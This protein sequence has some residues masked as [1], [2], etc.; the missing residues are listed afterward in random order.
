MINRIRSRTGG[1]KNGVAN[2]VKYQLKTNPTDEND[3]FESSVPRIEGESDWEYAKRVE[4]AF[5]AARVHNQKQLYQHN[6]LSFHPE[7]SKRLSNK[8]IMEIAKEFYLKEGLGDKN[9]H[10]VF[11]VER[12]TKHAH[13]HAAIHLTDLESKRVNNKMVNYKPIANRLEKKY[14]LYQVDRSPNPFNDNEPKKDKK[15]EIKDDLKSLMT[16]TST[17]SDFLVAANAAGYEILHNGNSA[18]SLEKDG[19]TFKA[20][21]VGASY[22]SLKARFGEDSEFASTLASLGRKTEPKRQMG[23]LTGPQ[24]AS[25]DD[26]VT[27]EEKVKKSKKTLYTRFDS[28]D[29]KF[30]FFKDSP[31]EAFRYERGSVTFNCMSPTAIK[32]GLQK[33]VEECEKKNDK[34]IFVTSDIR[35]FKR[36]TWIQFQMMGLDKKGYKL[37]GFEPSQLDHIELRK[38]K[39]EFESKFSTGNSSI[40]NVSTVKNPFDKLN[41]S[42]QKMKEI[43]EMK[44]ENE[45]KRKHVSNTRR[46]IMKPRL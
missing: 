44:K 9:R 40:T 31:R 12:D 45:E 25:A 24:F 42:A 10:Y 29:G 6:T 20:S 33:M 16:N 39:S 1:Y 37:N 4:R 5:E 2:T 43:E 7:E 36:E 35:S 41:E 15:K 34:E 18:Y 3:S 26:E 17:A 19:E 21:D 8:Q 22:K 28:D 27:K 32:A 46:N 14:G 11:V 38:R 23:S 13:V 30:F